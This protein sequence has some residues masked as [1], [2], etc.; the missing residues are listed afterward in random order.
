MLTLYLKAYEYNFVEKCALGFIT[1]SETDSAYSYLSC[2]FSFLFK[3]LVK[4]LIKGMV[5]GSFMLHHR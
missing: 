1:F 2:N 3:G 4:G 5:F